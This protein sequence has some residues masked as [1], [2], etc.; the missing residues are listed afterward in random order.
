MDMICVISIR[1][2]A[3]A[4]DIYISHC[5]LHLAPWASLSES[6]DG[7]FDRDDD[8]DQYLFVTI[9]KLQIQ[10][11]INMRTSPTITTLTLKHDITKRNTFIHSCGDL[12]IY[13]LRATLP[14]LPIVG[15]AGIVGDRKLRQQ[16]NRLPVTGTR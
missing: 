11:Y 9:T 10:R 3:G 4:C 2:N 13:P 12:P 16:V 15:R 8:D 1:Q 7:L 5:C 14:S 6:I